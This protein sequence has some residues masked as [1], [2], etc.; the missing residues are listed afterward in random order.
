MTK[1]SHGFGVADRLVDAREIFLDLL[2]LDRVLGEDA[3]RGLFALGGFVDLAGDV[4]LGGGGLT[5]I[6]EVEKQLLPVHR[7][8]SRCDDRD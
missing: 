4:R 2:R 8:F 7:V 6:A 1:S 5:E 3:A